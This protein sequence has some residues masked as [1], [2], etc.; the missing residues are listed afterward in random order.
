MIT[1]LPEA[2]IADHLAAVHDRQHLAIV[3]RFGITSRLRGSGFGSRRVE[4]RVWGLAFRE[5]SPRS[6][7]CAWTCGVERICSRGPGCWFEGNEGM[8][9]LGSR[10]DASGSRVSG[11][12]SRVDN[13]GSKVDDGLGSGCRVSKTYNAAGVAARDFAAEDEEDD[14]VQVALDLNA[15]CEIAEDQCVVG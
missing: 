1:L 11:L 3:S 4:S 2:L 15:A 6:C 5:V 14:G 9:G 13:L 12:G 10:V 7:Q 8:R